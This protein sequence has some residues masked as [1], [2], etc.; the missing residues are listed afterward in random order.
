VS[1]SQQ[2]QQPQVRRQLWFY[3][4]DILQANC[5]VISPGL[6]CSKAGGHRVMLL[7]TL[8]PNT[9]LVLLGDQ[10][11]EAAFTKWCTCGQTPCQYIIPPDVVAQA[12]PPQAHV[13]Q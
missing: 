8:P 13:P 12:N 1:S 10:T 5:I 4:P 2:Q 6:H 3:T 9:V 7:R 11:T